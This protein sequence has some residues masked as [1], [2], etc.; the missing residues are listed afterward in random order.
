MNLQCA[1]LLAISLAIGACE[2]G[3]YSDETIQ[4]C[5]DDDKGVA[6][7]ERAL[8]TVS[9]RYELELFDD[10]ERVRRDLDELDALPDQDRVIHWHSHDKS[11][12]IEITATNLGL[13]S[14]DVIV[15][16][17]LR[18][19]RQRHAASDLR[20]LLEQQFD[21]IQLPKEAGASPIKNCPPD[22][23]IDN[24]GETT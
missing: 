14:Y 5:L 11:E 15:S 22:T 8:R 24:K 16:Y 2:P 6:Y 17:D 20:G 19:A 7:F 3:R 13:G 9:T 12:G 4:L 1:T 21:V 10:S 18:S 23:A